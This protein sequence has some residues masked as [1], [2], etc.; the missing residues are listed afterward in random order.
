MSEAWHQ[1]PTSEEVTW[2]NKTEMAIVAE[3]EDIE[4]RLAVVLVSF[5]AF[6]L[7]PWLTVSGELVEGLFRDEFNLHV[8]RRTLRDELRFSVGKCRPRGE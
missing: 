1:S 6:V 4:R 5:H 8:G 3:V 2:D 7:E